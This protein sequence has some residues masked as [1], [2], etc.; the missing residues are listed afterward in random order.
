[1]ALLYAAFELIGSP[2]PRRDTAWLIGALLLGIA[3]SAFYWLPALSEVGLI[4]AGAAAATATVDT[5]RELAPIDQIVSPFWLH[6]YFPNQGTL[7]EN[8][9]GLVQALAAVLALF[10]AAVRW[11]SLD[12]AARRVLVW[13]AVVAALCIAL[14]L[15]WTRP[16]WQA[17]PGLTYLQ[18]PWRLQAPIGLT[19]SMLVGSALAIPTEP[20]PVDGGGLGWGLLAIAAIVG[21][22][23]MWSGMASLPIEPL[24]LP[25]HAEPL[26]EADVSLA[27]MAEYD[28]QTALWARLYGGPWLLEYLP[29]TVHVPREEFFLPDPAP[30]STPARLDPARLPHIVLGR[31]GALRRELTVDSPEGMTLRFHTFDFP[32]WQVRVDGVA[33]PTVASDRL[34]LVSADIPVG[35]HAITLNFEDTPSRQIGLVV[36]M[37]AGLAVL[38]FLAVARQWRLLIAGTIVAAM[39][40]ALLIIAGWLAPTAQAPTAKFVNLGDRA[41]LVGYAV[42]KPKPQPGDAV[43]VTL[44][45]LALQ[46]IERDYKVFVHLV[47]DGDRLLAQ[48]DSQPVFNFAPTTRWER[49][50]I[51][52]D[53]H[54]LVVPR[55]AVVGNY[56]LFVG[57]YRDDTG[58]RLP[59][60]D[61]RGAAVDT[62]IDLGEVIVAIRL[63]DGGLPQR[64]QR[65]K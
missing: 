58:E 2:H 41:A 42:D 61:A 35:R 33:V 10:V 32:G 34:G 50:E 63:C 28:Y 60:L 7:T 4:R 21:V 40:V 64:A 27:T 37:T 43:E 31:Q 14:M 15:D 48:H 18:Y 13:A 62:R 36:S 57:M 29:T 56:H 24:R 20:S 30:R 53:R 25:G 5:T 8:P 11:P 59:V 9:L 65:G 54:T 39:F 1:V 26:A 12:S 22:A 38:A 16:F 46:D 52:V 51:V 19:T 49:G 6:R 55:E 44:Y 23:M 17:V 3:A 45:W 47:G